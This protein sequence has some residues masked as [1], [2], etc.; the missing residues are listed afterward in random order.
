VEVEVLIDTR[1]QQPLEFNKSTI[2]KLDFGDYTL[3]GDDFTNTFVDR[4]SAGDFLSTFGGQ[5]DRF[6]REM[7]R[8]VELDSYMYIV[9]EKPL[10][11]I[12]KEAMFTKGRRVS[13][14]GWVFSNLISVQHEFAGHCQ[15]V[16]TDSRSHSE[17]IIPKL[18]SLGKKLWDVDV[19]YFLDKEER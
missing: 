10:A 12:E 18:L 1:E 15:F 7:Q 19:Q 5:V 3:G 6:R 16:F 11:A 8:C 9:V 4:K 14:L 2:L 17:E 13:K